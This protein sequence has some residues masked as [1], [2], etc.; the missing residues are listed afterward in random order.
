[1]RANLQHQCQIIQIFLALL[2]KNSHFLIKPSINSALSVQKDRAGPFLIRRSPAM[3][4]YY[5]L[6]NW[7]RSS[8]IR[9]PAVFC[10]AS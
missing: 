2:F 7:E 9:I 1:M 6:P 4:L 8:V 3:H 10:L 5:R